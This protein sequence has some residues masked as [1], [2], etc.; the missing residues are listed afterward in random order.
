MPSRPLSALI[1]SWAC[2]TLT[3]AQTP[4]IA[5]ADSPMQTPPDITQQTQSI[6]FPHHFVPNDEDLT[7]WTQIE[8]LFQQLIQQ[9]PDSPQALEQW[10]L[11]WNELQAC[12]SQAKLSRYI[13]MTC[14]TDDP[15][16][17]A[18]YL[19]FV[20]EI[21]PLCKPLHFQLKK[22]FL[23]NP[24]RAA[25]D[26]THYAVLCRDLE[27]DV[28]LYR[29]TNI[30]LETQDDKLRQQY[31][32]INGAMTVQ[33]EGE[34]KTLQQL[35]PY[36]EET[37]RAL[38]QNAWEATINRRVQDQEAMDD[39]Y[40]EMIQL[41]TQIAKNAGY[42]NYRDYI[43]VQKKRFDY[44][45]DDCIRFHETIEKWVVPLS[46]KLAAQ[47]QKALGLD[48]LRP[49]DLEVDPQGRPPLKAFDT[50]P[51]FTH[52]IQRILTRVHPE[53]AAQFEEMNRLGSLDLG[54]RK[55]KA[56]GGYC[57]TLEEIRRPFIF[58]NAV[59]MQDDVETLLHES[60]HAFHALA[61]RTQ[62]LYAYRYYVPLEFAEVASMS[63]ELF[64]INYLT[65]FYA[66]EE[67]QRAKRKQIEAIIHF[68]PWMAR[69]DAF[70][71]WAYTHPNHTRA[72]RAAAWL[73]LESRF[74]ARADWSG[75]EK[76]KA[77]EWHRKLH[78]F[79]YPF[80]YIEYGIA[81]VGALQLWRNFKEDPTRAVQDYRTA[82]ALGNSRPLPELFATAGAKFDFS[83]A[84]IRPLIQLL[85]EELAALPE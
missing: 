16:R 36:L 26:A 52:G 25:L 82:L 35:A 79:E 28:S 6:E 4:A 39:L 48:T 31:Q 41:R 18:A 20:E 8:P 30:P 49:W 50:I 32:K 78:F 43:F 40:D 84:T 67:A 65:E 14:H 81:Q 73:D 45:P 17:E 85:E 44:T 27:A 60:G 59:G 51:E 23:A 72:E 53:L 33:F 61:S 10:L 75:F 15:A 24:H 37:D 80:Y 56:P 64:G 63:M 77:V 55:G 34:E 38:R 42:E 83:E 1:L 21:D 47:Q 9:T 54:S 69:V 66:P 22:Q 76:A 71:H 19:H 3:W 68:L 74:D 70:Q 13:Q 12:L 11:D 57:E 5:K 46:R 58:M 2:V 7:Q 29:E 62:P